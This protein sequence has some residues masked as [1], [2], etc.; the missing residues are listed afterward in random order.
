L[1][2]IAAFMDTAARDEITLDT[3]GLSY[4]LKKRL[5]ALAERLESDPAD[6]AAFQ[7]FE[8]AVR[9][10]RSLPFE[11]DL[12]RAQNISYRVLQ[13]ICSGKTG[14]ATEQEWRQRWLA[15]AD[16][17]NLKCSPAAEQLAPPPPEPVPQAA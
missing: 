5:A 3:A 17:L 15:I 4:V 2:A 11:V 9:L 14:P 12:W 16:K 1:G 13:D 7:Q 8:I 6:S 10:A